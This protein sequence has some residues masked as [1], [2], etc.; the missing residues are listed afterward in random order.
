MGVA[1][2]VKSQEE[3]PEI[4]RKFVTES[5]GGLIMTSTRH[6]KRSKKNST[7]IKFFRK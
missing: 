3:V 6:S 2:N 5:D 1:I 7:I 4:M